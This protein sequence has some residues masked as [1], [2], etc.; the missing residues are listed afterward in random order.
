MS[1]ASVVVAEAK[2]AAVTAESQIAINA[3]T[4][5]GVQVGDEVILYRRVNVPDPDSGVSLG[6]AIYPK[7]H[8]KVN[9]VMPKFSVAVVVDRFNR[10]DDPWSSAVSGASVSRLKSVT[11]NPE[12]ESLGTVLLSVGESVTVKRLNDKAVT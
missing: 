7:L 10:S 12:E 9:M 4:E 6:S 1:E 2:V 5:N 8:L 3:G 11:T